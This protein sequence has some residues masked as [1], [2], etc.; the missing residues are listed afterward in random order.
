MGCWKGSHGQSAN[1]SKEQCMK[2][3]YNPRNFLRQVP[4]PLLKTFFDRRGE[5]SDIPWDELEEMD[6]D[7]VFEAWQALPEANRNDIERWFREISDLATSDG[8]QVLIEEGQFHGIDLAACM[9][10]MEG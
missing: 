2:L 7:P 10:Q 3:E 5:L 6:A 4:N 8:L 1:S 9:D